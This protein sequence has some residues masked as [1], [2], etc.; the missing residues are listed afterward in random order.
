MTT[1]RRPPL[2]IALQTEAT[3]LMSLA[4]GQ[5]GL[6][7]GFLGGRRGLKEIHG[8]N[9]FVI[10]GLT[11]ALLVTAV[12][13]FRRHGPRWP[14]IGAAILLVVEAAQI[15]MGSVEI[16]GPHIFLGV[17]F[18]VMATLLTSYLFRPG[19]TAAPEAS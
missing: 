15:V 13:Y 16:K 9:A 8:V 7:A 1:P 19:F 12:L 6:A 3:I 14:L 18:T 11:V 17:L 5:A 2:L 10:A 4:I